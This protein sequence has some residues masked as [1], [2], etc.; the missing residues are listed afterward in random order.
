MGLI[1]RRSRRRFFSQPQLLFTSQAFQQFRARGR[2]QLIP[3]LVPRNWGSGHGWEGVGFCIL[4]F[5]RFGNSNYLAT[6]FASDRERKGGEC[7][8]GSL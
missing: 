8:W 2:K 7:V 1:L 3:S 4:S 5:L 6:L